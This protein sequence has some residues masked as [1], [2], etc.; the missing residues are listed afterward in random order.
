LQVEPMTEIINT[1]NML[2]NL[3]TEDFYYYISIT[4]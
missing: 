3:N 2:H 4:H 1:W